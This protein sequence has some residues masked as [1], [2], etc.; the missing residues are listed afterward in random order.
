MS[1]TNDSHNGLFENILIVVRVRGQWIKC[2]MVFS[3]NDL[4]TDEQFPSGLQISH[5]YKIDSKRDSSVGLAEKV[6]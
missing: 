3:K 5:R 6:L 4:S 1:G 2:P